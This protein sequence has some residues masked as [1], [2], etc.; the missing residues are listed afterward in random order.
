MNFT[1]QRENIVIPSYDGINAK[2]SL[3]CCFYQSKNILQ[4]CLD[5]VTSNLLFLQYL[6]FHRI[7]INLGKKQFMLHY[8]H[9]EIQLKNLGFPNE[10]NNFDLR[11]IIYI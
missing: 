1:C 2:I 11:S 10:F 8:I 7:R 6:W 9:M 3:K 5:Q 4:D